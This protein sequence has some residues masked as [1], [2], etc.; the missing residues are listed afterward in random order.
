MSKVRLIAEHCKGIALAQTVKFLDDNELTLLACECLVGCIGMTSEP[1]ALKSIQTVRVK[2]S[3]T[4]VGRTLVR[5]T[6]T[7]RQDFGRRQRQL[8]HQIWLLTSLRLRIIRMLRLRLDIDLQYTSGQERKG[9]K[10]GLSYGKSVL[11]SLARQ[12]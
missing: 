4:L 6:R 3:Y 2:R 11:G 10:N 8:S 1:K 5:R 9:S 7:M 12:A